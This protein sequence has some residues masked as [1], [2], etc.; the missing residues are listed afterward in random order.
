MSKNV[1]PHMGN[2]MCFDIFPEGTEEWYPV[3]KMIS[4]EHEKKY[5]VT[6]IFL[7]KCTSF[8]KQG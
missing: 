8:G 5:I 2:W 3:G 1:Y 6:I 7:L 4:L